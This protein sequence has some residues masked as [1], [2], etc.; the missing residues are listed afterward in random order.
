MIVLFHPEA[1]KELS[2]AVS[3]YKDIS[4]ELAH[5]LLL[6]VEYGRAQIVDFPDA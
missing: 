1:L 2:A 3:Y 4:R 6:A 5:R